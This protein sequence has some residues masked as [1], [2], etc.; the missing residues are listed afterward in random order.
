MRHSHTRIWIHLIW[1]T[2]NRERCLFK[3]AGQPLYDHFLEK[4]KEL[5]IPFER[6]NIQPEHVHTLID[7]PTDKCLSEFMKAIKGES[8]H[9]MN[10]NRFISGHFEWQRGYGGYSVSA[11][12][13][14]IVKSYIQNQT[15]IINIK[16]LPKSMRNGNTGM[17]F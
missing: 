12:Q 16:P 9:W 15:P 4:A 10:Q 17:E 8:A 3:Q 7:L 11:S 14:D 6:L 5:G 1:A 13:V 2:K